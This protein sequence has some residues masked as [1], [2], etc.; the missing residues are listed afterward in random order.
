MI[1]RRQFVQTG[2]AVT[3]GLML[4]FGMEASDAADGG[5]SFGAYL[6]IAPDGT[7]FITCPQS[8]MGQGVH[9]GL[10][11]ILADEL[12]AD[13]ARVV[14][15]MPQADPPGPEAAGVEPI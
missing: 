14:V 11:K 15:R 13:W 2:V 8:E 4:N 7:V 3:G 6:E 9:D 5:A 1:S 12:G 10:P